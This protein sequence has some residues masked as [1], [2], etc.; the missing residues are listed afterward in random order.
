MP[1]PVSLVFVDVYTQC[2]R[3]ISLFNVTRR[4]RDRVSSSHREDMADTGDTQRA[5]LAFCEAFRPR[6]ALLENV[7]DAT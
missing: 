4:S 5:V 1:V 2:G 7:R 3:S 6:I